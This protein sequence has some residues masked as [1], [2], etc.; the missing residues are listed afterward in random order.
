VT[1]SVGQEPD[2]HMAQQHPL[3]QACGR[4][5]NSTHCLTTTQLLGFAAYGGVAVVGLL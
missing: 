4:Q 2:K 3:Q 1:S 5:N